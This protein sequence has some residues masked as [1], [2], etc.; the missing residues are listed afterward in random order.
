MELEKIFREVRGVSSTCFL[1]VKSSSRYFEILKSLI[2]S[3]TASGTA[4]PGQRQKQNFSKSF[5]RLLCLRLSRDIVQRFVSL[6]AHAKY[7]RQDRALS[8]CWWREW[9]LR[10]RWGWLQLPLILHILNRL[11]CFRHSLVLSRRK[12][13]EEPSRS[14]KMLEELRST[15]QKTWIFSR[16]FHELAFHFNVTWIKA[17]SKIDRDEF[18]YFE[19]ISQKIA[20]LLKNF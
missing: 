20:L 2:A 18:R 6:S 9:L 13:L 1:N 19:R 10:R 4:Q 16:I 17:F 12:I 3:S 5:E 7:L 15:L 11:L 8:R 14:S